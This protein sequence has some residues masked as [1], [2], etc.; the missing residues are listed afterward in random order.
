MAEQEH[1]QETS[2]RPGSIQRMFAR[3]IDAQLFPQSMEFIVLVEL[4]P[5]WPV[6]GNEPSRRRCM[7]L[8]SAG[9]GA[10]LLCCHEPVFTH[11]LCC[12]RPLC[13]AHQSEEGERSW[14]QHEHESQTVSVCEACLSL[15]IEHRIALRQLRRRFNTR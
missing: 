1:E 8:V 11:C 15:S 14:E 9:S 3:F 13:R 10:L 6:T 5:H 7:A 12:G 2:D 4:I